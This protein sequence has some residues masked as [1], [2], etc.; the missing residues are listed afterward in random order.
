MSSF[1]IS[2]PKDEPELR[3]EIEEQLA[4]HARVSQAP[5][6]FTDLNQIKLIVEIL[7]GVTS[8]ASGAASVAL[9]TTGIITFLLMLKDRYKNSKKPSSIRIAVP[10]QG[11]VALDEV[12]EAILKRILGLEKP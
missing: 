11:D 10:G 6:S 1:V 4:A 12:D 5:Q 3:D 8:I 9:S 2:I 7:A